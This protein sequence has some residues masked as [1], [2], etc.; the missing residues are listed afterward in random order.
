M[1]SLGSPRKIHTGTRML[2]FFN[3]DVVSWSLRNLWI[4]IIFRCF[5][6]VITTLYNVAFRCLYDWTLLGYGIQRMLMLRAQRVWILVPP[7]ISRLK[8]TSI[9]SEVYFDLYPFVYSFYPL[10]PLCA[11]QSVKTIMEEK[12]RYVVREGIYEVGVD[13]N[14]EDI[15][16]YYDDNAQEYE[17]VNSKQ[18]VFSFVELNMSN[19][20]PK[21]CQKWVFSSKIEC[22]FWQFLSK[23]RKIITRLGEKT[24]T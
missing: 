19:F 1:L 2:D 10:T 9:S 11:W 24:S 13:G 5:I 3:K 8:A 7:L 22:H 16:N 23:I 14:L 18:G 21:K 6:N 4:W 12:H 17:Q 15:R 20:F